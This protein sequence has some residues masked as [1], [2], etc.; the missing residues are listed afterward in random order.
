MASQK[1]SISCGRLRDGW[2]TGND[3]YHDV[4]YGENNSRDK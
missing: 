2:E 1:H 3:H 4:C